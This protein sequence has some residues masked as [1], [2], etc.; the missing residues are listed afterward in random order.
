MTER[1]VTRHLKWAWVEYGDPRD[2][3]A[4]AAGLYTMGWRNLF[5]YLPRKSDAKGSY[6]VD[7]SHPLL[8]IRIKGNT[9]MALPNAVVDTETVSPPFVSDPIF[10]AHRAANGDEA[11]TAAIK[12]QSEFL[13]RWVFAP[14]LKKVSETE[15]H[16]TI[17]SDFTDYADLVAI[18]G[19]GAGGTVWGGDWSLGAQIGTAAEISTSAP[20]DRLKYVLV[21]T[22]YNLNQHN[23]ET[24]VPLFRRTN[25]LHGML[26]YAQ[27]YPG[28]A[29]GAG[30]FARFAE[31]LKVSG[32]TILA[33]W[34]EAHTGYLEQRWG[35]MLHGSAIKDTMRDWLAGA[36]EAPDPNGELR[37]YNYENY[38]DGIPVEEYDP[39]VKAHF[40]MGDTKIT[41]E[42][43]DSMDV[44]LFSGESGTLEIT[45]ATGPFQDGRIVT[46]AFYYY[47]PDKDGMNLTRLLSFGSTPDA[48]VEVLTDYN[49]RDGTANAD[50]INVTIQ[51]SPSAVR[52][53]FTV[54][55]D[56]HEAYHRHGERQYGY[57][58]MHVEPTGFNDASLYRSGAY[59][60]GPR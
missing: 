3:S 52:I 29:T 34:K 38:P 51:G 45:N 15:S 44:G 17:E 50:A 36:L 18:S 1:A 60:R 27:S 22:C 24:W 54:P 28:G 13:S 43:K 40:Y 32:K 23:S 59:L 9:T 46:I 20:S 35:A 6:Y 37:W 42:N 30:V 31:N 48:A 58:W 26:G 39:I 47:R 57:F 21:P 41:P 56:A 16:L 14:G 5:A 7:S 8:P 19:H 55:A 33:A 4:F 10:D 53:P 11:F 49:Q 25:P 2:G 12:E